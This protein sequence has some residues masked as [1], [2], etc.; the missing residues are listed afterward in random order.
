MLIL[1]IWFLQ[2]L[3]S[4]LSF[5][6]GTANLEVTWGYLLLR[7]LTTA[8]VVYSKGLAI[9]PSILFSKM[10]K[11]KMWGTVK[12]SKQ[13]LLMQLQHP[14]LCSLKDFVKLMLLVHL[15]VFTRSILQ[16]PVQDPFNFFKIFSTC[17]TILQWVN[18]GLNELFDIELWSL[19]NVP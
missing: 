6:S 18:A 2:A 5:N 11:T 15:M 19:Y 13:Y 10:I 17:S 12:T 1:S 16:V 14:K 7:L 9:Y 3:L 8:I 4:Q